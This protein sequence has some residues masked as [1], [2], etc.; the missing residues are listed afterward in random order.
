MKKKL[1]FAAAALLFL[2]L[3]VEKSEVTSLA[4][5]VCVGGNEG[6]TPSLRSYTLSELSP[7]DG[8]FREIFDILEASDYRRGGFARQTDSLPVFT[9]VLVWG[10]GAD[11]C[12]T[13]SLYG[14]STLK[15]ACGGSGLQVWHP[16]DR[17][18]AEALT[19]Y[20]QEHGSRG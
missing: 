4:C 7:Q 8:S 17:G 13:L 15:V 11:E 19:A 18:P 16:T 6:G 1:I 10:S 20:L 5:T 3:P 9:A 14:A 2:G 12:C